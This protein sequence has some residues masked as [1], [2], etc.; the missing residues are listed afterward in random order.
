V[1]QAHNVFLDTA[2]T[3]GLPGIMGLLLLLTGMLALAWHLIR[4]TLPG[5]PIRPLT[6]GLIA[7]IIVFVVFGMTDALSLS[8]PSALV[9]WLWASTMVTL[10]SYRVDDA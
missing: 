2:L 3:L 9:V 10:V 8:T 4:S 1:S 7:A 6:F 5:N